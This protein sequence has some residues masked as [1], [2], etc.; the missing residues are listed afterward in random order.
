MIKFQPGQ[1]VCGSV[2]DAFDV[3]DITGELGYEVQV[4]H[5]TGG[6]LSGAGAEGES[7]WLVVC[8]D[9][10]LS[11]FDKVL[12]VLDGF[13]DCQELTV[14]CAVVLLGRTQLPREVGNGA[15]D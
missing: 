6:R 2:V 12:E 7:Q 11:S 13:V 3:P 8:C 9:V 15:P 14:K 10:E 1:G 4:A 5:L